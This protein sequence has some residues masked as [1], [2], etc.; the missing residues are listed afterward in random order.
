MK[1]FKEN[2]QFSLAKAILLV[3]LLL[4]L[5][6]L[7]IF[8]WLAPVNKS[9]LEAEGL[10]FLLAVGLVPGLIVALFQYGLSWME[11]RE[12]DRIRDMRIQKVLFTRDDPDYYGA[13]INESKI[14]VDVLGVTA[15]RFLIDFADVDSPKGSK[16]V[17]VSALDRGVK[18]RILVAAKTR[19]GEKDLGEKWPALVRSVAALCEK[20]P[21]SFL[22]KTYDERPSHSMVRI[23]NHCIV[24]PIFP[25][26]ESKN[27][28]AVH[29][30]LE[31]GFA[32]GYIKH[33]ESEW[34]VATNFSG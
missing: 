9:W 6:F 27:S 5:V 11:F 24:G 31:N 1:I 7:C 3:I 8:I 17:L 21:D 18:V 15:S 10:L 22:V 2:I 30:L 34:Q 26:V 25:L 33:F 12:V 28:P 16:K 20:Y 23:D 13:L 19:L 14:Q 32:Q 29:T 4:T